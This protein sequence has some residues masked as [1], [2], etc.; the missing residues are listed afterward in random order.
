MKRQD[1]E[2]VITVQM[3]PLVWIFLI[4]RKFAF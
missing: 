3:W 1:V 4:V 2:E